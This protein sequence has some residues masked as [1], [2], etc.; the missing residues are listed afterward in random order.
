M[1]GK[2][3]RIQGEDRIASPALLYYLDVI[4]ENTDEVIRIAGSAD[5]LWPH[6]KTHKSIDMIR[7]LISKG[8]RKFKCATIPECEMAAMAGATD[9][10]LAY[11]LIGPAIERFIKLEELYPE[12]AFYAIGDDYLPIKELS[13]AEAKAGRKARFLLDVNMGMNRTG[14]GLDKAEDLAR[15]A[16]ALPGL[17]FCG[18]HCYDGNHNNS[19]FSKR[20]AEVRETDEIVNGIRKSL[21]DDGIS[22]RIMI[23]GGT[24]SFPCHAELTDY[25][26]S[27][28]TCFVYDGG[29]RKNLPDLDLTPAGILL[30]RVVSHPAEGMFTIDLGYK[31]IASDP[32]GARGTIVGLEDA[33]IAFQS[34]EHW[35]FRMKPGK[36]ASRPAVGDVLYVIPTHI[37]P[38]S[39]LYSDILVVEGDKVT[40]SW[41]VTARNRKISI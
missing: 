23:M 26:L 15:K 16:A 20:L 2:N 6:V 21:E 11:P 22:C 31:G 13:D 35:V 30:T 33:E 9:A 18:M 5:R 34:E 28:G 7:L 25:Y 27:P 19:D 37:C 40:Q 29:Y 39:A 41:P 4:K 14:I 24:P 38:T 3:Y 12:C 32:A 10:V 36:E 8:I 1:T 17:D